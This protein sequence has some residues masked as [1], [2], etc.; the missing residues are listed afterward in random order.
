MRKTC[1]RAIP[2]ENTAMAE[3]SKV[4]RWTHH[5]QTDCGT[6]YASMPVRIT[7]VNGTEWAKRLANEGGTADNSVPF[8]RDWSFFFCPLLRNVTRYYRGGN[9]Y[10]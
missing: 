7:G 5:F 3:S 6:L 9:I 1:P 8:V 2:T 10:V 4:K